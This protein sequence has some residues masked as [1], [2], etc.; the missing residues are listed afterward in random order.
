MA[1]AAAETLQPPYSTNGIHPKQQD[2]QQCK[3]QQHKQQERAEL[4][5]M[6]AG[7]VSTVLWCLASSTLIVINNSLYKGG[8]PYPMMV[9]GIGQVR[10]AADCRPGLLQLSVCWCGLSCLVLGWT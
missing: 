5:H 9:T 4:L 1:K 3:V 8:F 10:A 2:A 6:A 7:L